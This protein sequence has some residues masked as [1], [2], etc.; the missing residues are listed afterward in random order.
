MLTRNEG[1]PDRI[2][3]GMGGAALVAA[4]VAGP[5]LRSPLGIVTAVVG[6]VLLL[7]AATGFCLVYRLFGIDTA[8]GH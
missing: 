5:G 8:K 6:A 3:R 7:T 1:P 4:A 2:V